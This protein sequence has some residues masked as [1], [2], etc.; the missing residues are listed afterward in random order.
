MNTNNRIQIAE[1]DPEKKI[2]IV[3]GMIHL[4]LNLLEKEGYT[5]GA[6][7][8]DNTDVFLNDEGHLIVRWGDANGFLLSVPMLN[9][10]LQTIDVTQLIVAS[11]AVTLR[12]NEDF[13][14]TENEQA[15][16]EQGMLI[17]AMMF[18]KCM[19]ASVDPVNPT[20]H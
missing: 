20:K 9:Q 18:I 11:S 3:K 10:G 1:S 15:L 6:F 7:D 5:V 2:I 17:Y 4:A 19:T 16:F 12:L 14:L 13:T 8:G